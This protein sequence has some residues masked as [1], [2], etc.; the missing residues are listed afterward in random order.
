MSSFNF[1]LQKILEMRIDKEETAKL[2]LKKVI[3]EKNKTEEKLEKL[4]EK[5]EKTYN[6]KNIG[7]VVE[8]KLKE[9]YLN[10]LDDE[11]AVTKDD[12]VSCDENVYKK[13][14]DLILAQRDK[15]SVDILKEKQYKEFVLE[16]NS[17]E[18]RNNDEFALYGYIRNIE[19]R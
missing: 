9:N 12:I 19:R 1:R 3:D 2:E 16:E 5:F 6:N 17:I 13:R 8:R 7:N 18:Q 15:K 4:E 14:A 11:I 10:K